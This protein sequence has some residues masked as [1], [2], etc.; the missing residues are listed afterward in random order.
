MKSN[1][2]RFSLFVCAISGGFMAAPQM[3]G[4]AT[5]VVSSLGDDGSPGQLR[6]LINAAAP[7][8]TIVVPAGIIVLSGP[9]FENAN[10]GGDLDIAKNLTIQGAGA[11][12]AIIDG[13]GVD[14]V[15][16]IL[17]GASVVISGVTIGGGVANDENGT[18]ALRD[19]TVSGNAAGSYGGGVYTSGTLA[20][21]NCTV[22][23]NSGG[24]GAGIYNNGVLTVS[25]SAITGNSAA[26]DGGGL[27][28]LGGTVTATNVTIS[29][30]TAARDGGGAIGNGITTLINVTLTNNIADSDR[31]GTG[32][33]GGI[34]NLGA[35][36]LRNTIIAGNI[37][38][39]GEAPDCRGP[40]TT[41]GYNLVGNATGCTF[42]AGAGDQIGTG[43]NPV[44]PNLGP[45]A[46]NG[47]ATQTHALLAGSA[48]INAGTNCPATD[49]RGAARPT[50]I[51]DSG[52]YQTPATFASSSD[53]LFIWAERTY[54]AFFAPAGAAT[55]KLAQYYYRYYAQ[56]QAYLGTSSENNHVYYFGPLSGNSLFDLGNLSDWLTT[57]GC[58]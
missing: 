42:V 45:L 26:F 50:G 16:H 40:I 10:A 7:G 37:D 2:L 6:T 24:S 25:N 41:S 49:Q 58:R 56:S 38:R 46:S 48:A 53:C 57:A 44:N 31:D 8:D 29:G 39:G 18:L 15:F 27:A 3:A 51:C 47:G 21:S 54:A 20:I 22:T 30:N 14:R 34:R 12:A 32:D 55:V 33:A 52:A 17:S 11:G 35:H 23:G 13:G 4:A 9:A 19:C 5:L 1:V 36:D 43:T 28:N